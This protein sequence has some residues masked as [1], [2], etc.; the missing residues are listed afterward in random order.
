MFPGP[1]DKGVLLNSYLP[2]LPNSLTSPIINIGGGLGSRPMFGDDNVFGTLPDSHILN[3]API[4][5]PYHMVTNK[6]YNNE[7]KLGLR[8]MADRGSVEEVLLLEL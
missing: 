3:S 7:A 1:L 4:R 6:N 5:H 2:V 8:K